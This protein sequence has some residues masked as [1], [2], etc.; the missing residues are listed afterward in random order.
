MPF[1]LTQFN[2]CWP[3][4][5]MILDHDKKVTKKGG[6]DEEQHFVMNA[7]ATRHKVQELFFVTWDDDH[8]VESNAFMMSID[9]KITTNTQPSHPCPPS[10]VASVT[11]ILARFISSML[12]HARAG[13]TRAQ[14]VFA[15]SLART[16]RP[17]IRSTYSFVRL[18]PLHSLRSQGAMCP[19]WS[20][21]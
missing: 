20:A 16:P 15:H 11:L 17:P 14:F 7:H 3:R 2:M 1:S 21:P 9:C 5:Q 19:S 6:S 18:P 4:I 8:R 13:S 10:S 12:V